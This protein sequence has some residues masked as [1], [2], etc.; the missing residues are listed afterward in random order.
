[1][2]NGRAKSCRTLS[3]GTSLFRSGS[4]MS[5]YNIVYKSISNKMVSANVSIPSFPNSLVL[6]G[7]EKSEN[8]NGH[9]HF[10]NEELYIHPLIS[11]L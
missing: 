7:P 4:N 11:T 3:T 6:A 8:F 9:C 5:L 1:M 2:Q 10:N